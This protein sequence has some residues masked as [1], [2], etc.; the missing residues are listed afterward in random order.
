MSESARAT[1]VRQAGLDG[2]LNGLAALYDGV[3]L[4]VASAAVPDGSA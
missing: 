2:V 3:P 4:P 1:V